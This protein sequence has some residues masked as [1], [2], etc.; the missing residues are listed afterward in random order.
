MSG[1]PDFAASALGMLAALAA[2]L[3]AVAAVY[4]AAR[5]LMRG[6]GTASADAPIRVLASQ[7]IGV[8]KNI[9][10]V[11]V[12]GSVLVLGIS[13][14]RI[15]LLDKIED[16]RLLES[17]RSRL[18]GRPTAFAVHLA[19]LGGRLKARGKGA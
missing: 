15:S 1:A 18:E 5:R 2:V 19:R 9:A 11:E 7:F 4:L 13:G 14:E 8:K 16:P 6:Q 17:L 12:P 10:L 3:A